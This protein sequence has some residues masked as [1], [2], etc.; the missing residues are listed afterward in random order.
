M[1]RYVLLLID[2]SSKSCRL[3]VNK[4]INVVEAENLNRRDLRQNGCRAQRVNPIG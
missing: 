1:R 2:P 4:F 3:V